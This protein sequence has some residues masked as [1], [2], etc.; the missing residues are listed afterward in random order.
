[1]RVAASGVLIA[2]GALAAAIIFAAAERKPEPRASAKPTY[3]QLARIAERIDRDR[4]FLAT[5]GVFLEFAGVGSGCV[6]VSLANPTAPN[7]EYMKRRFPK[8]C[9]ERRPVG[10]IDACLVSKATLRGGL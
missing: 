10:P 9:V 3:G 7:V 1:M 8:V 6:L 4:E 5:Q 2:L